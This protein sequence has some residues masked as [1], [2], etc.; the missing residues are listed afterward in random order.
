MIDR[1]QTLN[2]SNIK[3]KHNSSNQSFKGT[4]A[5]ALT[6]LRML[7]NSPAIGACA[8]DL[9]SMVIPR[10]CIEWKNRGRQSGTETLIR[11][12]TSNLIHTGVGVIGLGA[13][14]AISGKFNRDFGVKAQNIFASGDTI[15]SMSELW[16]NAQ[17]QK[18]EFFQGFLYAKI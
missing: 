5:L 4:G 18:K 13:A 11:E 7:N 1:I 9:C 2:N 12:G 15:K 17:G 14:A 10:T 3:A 16:G 6:G 8:V